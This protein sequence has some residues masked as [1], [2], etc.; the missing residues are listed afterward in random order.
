MTPSPLGDDVICE[1]TFMINDNCRPVNNRPFTGK[2]NTI[3]KRGHVSTIFVSCPKKLC[4]F[5]NE[6]IKVEKS[7]GKCSSGDGEQLSL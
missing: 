6:W 4:R 1:I 2:T 5:F 7:F 3:K